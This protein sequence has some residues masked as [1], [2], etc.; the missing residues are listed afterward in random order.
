MVSSRTTKL[1]L[2][3]SLVLYSKMA[4]RDLFV[5]KID[6]SGAQVFFFF[7]AILCRDSAMIVK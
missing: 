5:S 2:L 6:F 1:V 4:H 7:F 3:L